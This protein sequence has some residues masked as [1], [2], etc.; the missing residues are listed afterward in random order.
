M[1][2]A[3]QGYQGQQFVTV[4][5]SV[6]GVAIA[7]IPVIVAVLLTN[8]APAA[9]RLPALVAGGAVYGCALAVAGVRIAARAAEGRLPEITQ[10]AIRS[11]L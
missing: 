1:R 7:A 4:L 11:T 5:G 2:Q 3:A 9:A 6:G 10:I 8:T